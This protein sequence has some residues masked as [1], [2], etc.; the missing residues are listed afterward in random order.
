MK[1]GVGRP[2]GK[3]NERDEKI[4]IDYEEN[5]ISTQDIGAK[6]NLSKRRIEMLAKNNGWKRTGKVKRTTTNMK[7]CRLTNDYYDNNTYVFIYLIDLEEHGVYIG[8]TKD[9]PQRFRVHINDIKKRK[10]S[11][12]IINELA[13]KDLA[14]VIDKFQRPTILYANLNG[15]VEE[16]LKLEREYQI[17]YI[18]NGYRVLG[19]IY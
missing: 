11:S 1:N 10:H 3:L 14:Y 17:E 7:K 12:R 2:S 9:I 6:Y 15:S 19:G 5:N 4:R 18:D 13:E 16:M 8:A